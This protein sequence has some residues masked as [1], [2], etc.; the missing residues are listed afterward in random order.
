MA[1]D[2]FK[3]FPAQNVL[4]AAGILRGNG[5]VHS[6]RD[7][8]LGEQ[9]VALIH[10]FGDFL[11]FSVREI[12]PSSPMVMQSCS[13]RFLMATLTLGLENPISAAMST[14]RTVP[15]RSFSTRIVSR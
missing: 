7:Q 3:S 9:R 13:R 11:A 15:L 12:K 2:G 8:P 4:N 10:A 5:R 6:Q 1:F 14:E